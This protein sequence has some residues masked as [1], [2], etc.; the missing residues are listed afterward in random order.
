LLALRHFP[1]GEAMSNK[2]R[3]LL[4]AISC[5]SLTGCP[6]GGDGTGTGATEASSGNV[7]Y[8]ADQNTVGVFELFLTSSGVK[9]NPP[10]VSGG[11]VISFALT[12]DKNSVVYIADQTTDEVFELYQVNIA[13]PG[14]SVKLNGTLIPQGDVTNFAI[15]LDG[16]SVVY[17]AD[18]RLDQVFEV[19][20]VLFATPQAST[21]LNPALAAGRTVTQF[22]VTPDSTKV[23]YIANQDTVNV[24]EL[25]QVAFVLPQNSTKLNALLVSPGGNVTDFAITPNSVAVVYLADQNI[26]QV[27]EIF[28]API[29]GPG[30]ATSLNPPLAAPKSVTAFAITPDNAAVIY[31]ADQ[32]TVGTFELYRVTFAFPQTSSVKL[33]GT[34]VAGGNVRSFTIAANSSPCSSGASPTNC[35]AVVYSAD[36]DIFGVVELF[37]VA[38]SV[39]QPAPNPPAPGPAQKI[40]PTF[41][42]PQSVSAFAITPDSSAA[43]YLANQ[44]VNTVVQLYRVPFSCLQAN[45]PSSCPQAIPPPVNL[46]PLNGTLVAGGNVKSFSVTPNSTLVLYLADQTTFGVTELYA[47]NVG[48]P[49]ASSKLNGQLVPGGNVTAFTF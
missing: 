33:N 39:S 43:V 15:T 1:Y 5:L 20:R 46:P 31:R 17:L 3:L 42:A 34:L 23:V 40:N 47:V 38:L 19:F 28:P 22:A 35:S 26:D 41:V 36:Q 9:L 7:V 32:T 49:G 12:P 18:Q 6:G 10:L 48:S 13:T 29:T 21:L 25:F 11:N 44:T 30:S 2:Y 4:I 24:N 8:L 27:F 16:T 14:V 45:P 37:R